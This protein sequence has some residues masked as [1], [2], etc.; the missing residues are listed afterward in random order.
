MQNEV[1]GDLKRSDRRLTG[2][3]AVRI[4]SQYFGANK[5]GRVF[6]KD[7]D[8]E[9]HLMYVSLEDFSLVFVAVKW[10]DVQELDNQN[11]NSMDIFILDYCSHYR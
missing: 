10:S 4:P 7:P 11:S 1:T 6:E 5:S 3:P 2:E 8:N 9:I